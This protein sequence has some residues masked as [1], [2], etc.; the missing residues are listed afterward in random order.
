MTKPQESDE[1]EPSGTLETPL[2]ETSDEGDTREVMTQSQPE[3]LVREHLRIVAATD[4]DAVDRNVTSD[5]FNH[6]SADE[7]METRQRGPDGLK[8]LATSSECCSG[9]GV[10]VAHSAARPV[11]YSAQIRLWHGP[12]KS[13]GDEA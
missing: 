4:F 2:S 1:R 9:G 3:R 5:Y 7:P 12:T 11:G 8:G 13:H 6:R 10:K